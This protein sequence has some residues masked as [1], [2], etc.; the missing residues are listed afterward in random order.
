MTGYEVLRSTER[1]KN[2]VFRIV[3]DEV[4]M[5]DGAVAERDY[6]RHV[7]AVGVVALDAD[8]NVVLVRQYRHALGREIWEL[9]AGLIDVPG[10]KLAEAAARELA[11]EVDLRAG[12]YDLLVDM[13]PSPGCS[14]EVIRLFLARDLDEVP[15]NDRHRRTHEEAGM[16]VTRVP[17]DRAVTMA[18]SGEITNAACLVGIL[19]TAQA[20]ARNWATL[21]QVD[22]P[23][24]NK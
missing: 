3:T 7:G 11:E 12:R 2:R 10:E 15:E 22:E 20:K 14:D 17:L 8:E 24:P 6:M 4:R 5:P 19:A 16:T 13:N 21:R 9:P 23:L 18:L 1:L